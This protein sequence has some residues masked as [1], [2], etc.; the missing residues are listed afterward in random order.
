MLTPVTLDKERNICF[1]FGAMRMFK[2]MTGKS[3]TKI[4]FE[5]EDVEDLIPTIIYCG[6]RAEDPDLT[7]EKTVELL[8][9]YLD[10]NKTME[11]LS[12]AFKNSGLSVEEKQGKNI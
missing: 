6:L 7:V 8:D 3:L 2:S 9:T 4:D 10:F 11:L 5:K 12:K 1:G